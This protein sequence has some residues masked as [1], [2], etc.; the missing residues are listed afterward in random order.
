MTANPPKTRKEEEKEWRR[1]WNPYITTRHYNPLAF[2]LK[3][4]ATPLVKRFKVT[5]ELKC[6]RLGRL[7]RLGW[8][9]MHASIKTRRSAVINT[10]RSMPQITHYVRDITLACY[11]NSKALITNAY[12]DALFDIIYVIGSWLG[13]R[14]GGESDGAIGSYSKGVV[15]ALPL[16]C[17]E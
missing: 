11:K 12:R 16:P 10:P 14:G 13:P 6:K 8:E 15:Y 4:I 7:G 3:P 5:L 1:P 2:R 17:N 9:L